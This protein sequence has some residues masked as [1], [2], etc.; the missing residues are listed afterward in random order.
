MRL[1]GQH[2]ALRDLGLVQCEIALHPDFARGNLRPAGA[3]DAG[4]A[5]VR[6][7]EAGGGRGV[8]DRGL[9]TR[10]R[11][12]ALQ[13]V[14][15]ASPAVGSLIV[16]GVVLASVAAGGMRSITLACRS[17]SRSRNWS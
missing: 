8:E 10:K 2:E 17:F 9:A 16:A 11:E 12:L 13:T 7:L 5:G 6:H 15:G 3:A 14:T 4:G 1:A